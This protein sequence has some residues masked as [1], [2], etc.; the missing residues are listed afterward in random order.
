MI[1]SS[2]PSKRFCPLVINK[3][4]KLPLRS[5]GIMTLVP[6]CHAQ[7]EEPQTEEPQSEDSSD[8][9]EEQNGD[10]AQAASVRPIVFQAAGPSIASIQAQSLRF[11]L[12]LANPTMA[13]SRD[14]SWWVAAKSTGTVAV[15]MIPL[16]NR[17][18]PSTSS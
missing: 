17:L 3:G 10:A 18:H 14:R 9:A 4:S 12:L 15:P 7:T 1:F 8:A 11:A 2:K 5:R 6:V 13:T 16:T